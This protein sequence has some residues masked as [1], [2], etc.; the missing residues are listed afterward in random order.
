MAAAPFFH[1]YAVEGIVEGTDG[2][3][4]ALWA[5]ALGARRFRLAAIPFALTILSSWYLGMVG[6]LLLAMATVWERRA[7]WSA[8]GLILM[9]PAIFQFAQAFPE[10]APLEAAVRAAM[11]ASVSIPRPG[12]MPGLQPFAI[13]TYIGFVT[14]TAALCSRTMWT[15]WAVIPA[16]LSLGVGPIY[17]APVAE[18]IRFPYRW[19]AATLLLLAPAAAIA[20]DARKWGHWLA[21]IIVLEG[22]LLSPIEPIIPSSPTSSPPYVQLIDGPVL[23]IPG[24]YAMPPGQINPSRPRAQYLLYYQTVHRHPTPWVPDFNSV[25]VQKTANSAAMDS[26]VQLDPLADAPLPPGLA[27]TWLI[28]NGVHNV[29]LHQNEIG[30]KQA[31]LLRQELFKTGWHMVFDSDAHQLFQITSSSSDSPRVSPRSKNDIYQQ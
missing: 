14:L 31:T 23:D 26:F 17:D 25:G 10:T 12:L 1:G 27:I 24:P 18:L 19:H 28:E 21:P 9:S 7:L 6:C 13:N 20:A 11:G 2:W 8:M 5:W 4:L 3:T 22:L 29:V 15:A 16:L 30:K